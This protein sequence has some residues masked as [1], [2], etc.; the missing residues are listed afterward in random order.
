MGMADV[1]TRYIKPVE[2]MVIHCWQ[3][4]PHG[5]HKKMCE[6]NTSYFLTEKD[7]IDTTVNLILETCKECRDA[8]WP[9]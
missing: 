6:Q 1:N 4:A 9:I 5:M 8:G 7:Y 2:D 3:L